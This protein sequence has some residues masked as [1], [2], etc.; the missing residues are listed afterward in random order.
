MKWNF[1][2]FVEGMVVEGF[3][4]NDIGS[5]SKNPIK[6]FV[7]EAIQNSCDALNENS[8]EEQVK[9]VIKKGT[10]QKYE[11]EEFEAIENHLKA[12]LKGD[13]NTAEKREIRRHIKAI[14]S[15]KYSYIEISDYNTT[16]MSERAFNFLTES[17]HKSDKPSGS[18]GSKGVGKAAYL[19]SSYLRTF[20]VSS[21]HK[22]KNR[23]RGV[24]RL[25]THPDPYDESNILYHQG[26]Y[27]KKDTTDWSSIPRRFHRHKNGTS[28]YIIGA[29]DYKRFEQN[30]IEEILRNYWFAIATSQLMVSVGDKELNS[31]TLEDYLYTYFKDYKD[32]KTGNK[33]NPLPYYETYKHGK[34]YTGEIVNLGECSVWFQKNPE[35]NLGA[36]AR[37]RKTKMLIYKEN[38]IDPGYAGIF[39]CDTKSGNEFLKDLEN[40]AHNEWNS[41]NNKDESTTARRT[42][43]EIRE[44][45]QDKFEKYAGI[46]DNDSFT[47]DILDDFFSFSGIQGIKRPKEKEGNKPEPKPLP[48]DP[49]EPRDRILSKQHCTAHKQGTKYLYDIKFNSTKA[50]ENQ[51]L[52]LSIA[53]DSSRDSIS[54]KNI[55]TRVFENDIIMMDIQEGQNIIKG[56]ELDISYLVAPELKSLKD[57]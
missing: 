14:E 25:A 47:S 6:S 48:D 22:G 35:F 45:I 42:I 38:N 5:F 46:K 51:R 9:V 34:K 49:P 3:N 54:I 21:M 12:C 24:S 18:Q 50:V 31:E 32:N 20:I 28:I 55:E 4:D 56:I 11:L 29:W 30:V 41:N 43:R 53:T 23:F 27:G 2:D 52:Q 57:N 10:L 7:R 44:F 26:Y 39:L 13:I 36:V 33:Q 40:D 8:S 19:A 16:G 1:I 37:F 17:K 15:T